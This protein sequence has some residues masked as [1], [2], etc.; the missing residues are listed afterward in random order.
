MDS[1]QENQRAGIQGRTHS[2]CRSCGKPV[3]LQ[4]RSAFIEPNEEPRRSGSS[5]HVWHRECFDAY[6]EEGEET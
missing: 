2:P 6:L 5:Q 1:K 4:G 3:Q